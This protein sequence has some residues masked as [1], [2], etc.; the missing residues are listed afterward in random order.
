MQRLAADGRY[1]Y[2]CDGRVF[3]VDADALMHPGGRDILESYRGRD[4][5]SAFRGGGTV[6]HLHSRGAR[7]LLD[8]YCVGALEGAV[9]GGGG[10]GSVEDEKRAA[11]A[12]AA[13]AAVDEARPLLPQVVKLDPAAYMAWV[14]APS[15]GHPIMFANSMMERMTSTPWFVVPLLWVPVACALLH[16]AHTRLGL[17]AA[18]LPW[19][20][21][22]GVLGWQLVEYSIHRWLFHLKPTG[23]K[24][25]EL[26]FMLHGHHHKYPMDVDRLVF[27]PL[28]AGLAMGLFFGL[29][30]SLLPLAW[31]V[32]LMGGGILGY[33]AYDTTHWALHSNAWDPFVTPKL[34]TSHMDHHYV[35]DT[36]GYGISSTLYDLLFGTLSPHLRKL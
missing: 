9:Q 22:V 10:G 16:H 2:V 4:I 12:A 30:A 29:L 32:A 20:V 24:S 35:N 7:A 3:D 27:P 5:S 1:V 15:T 21:A 25:I 11:L 17:A 34:R 8:A 13:A 33:T 19:A 26:H 28:P 14:D 23:P 31:A 6:A 18:S 36:V